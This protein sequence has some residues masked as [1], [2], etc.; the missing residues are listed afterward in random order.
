MKKILFVAN[1]TK[2]H[3]CK[4]HIPTIRVFKE[5][6]WTVDVAS[7]GDEEVPYCDHHFNMPWKRSPFTWKTI[8]GIF[9]LRK[10]IEDGKYDVVYC[11]TPVGGLVARLAARKARKYGTKVVY[12]AHGLHF[13]H[14]A[15]L[16][17][18]LLYYPVEKILSYFTDVLFVVNKD[19][20]QQA[21]K[22]L[23][24]NRKMQTQLVPGVGV[25]FE[26]L[27]LDNREEIRE[28]YR[29]TLGI[30][31][32]TTA[33]IYVAE[34]V[35]NKNQMMLVDVLK[36]LRE[37]GEDVVLLLPGPEHS[38]IIRS[39]VQKAGMQDYVYLLGWRNDIGALLCCADI[40]T[41]SSIREGFGINL[42]EALY[43]ELPIVATDNRGH[44]EIIRDGENGFLV[45]IN[46]V[47]AMSERVLQL[48][49][50]EELRK[51]LSHFDVSAYDCNL[52][53]EKLYHLIDNCVEQSAQ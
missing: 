24:G 36:K 12:C 22:L 30:H 3:I 33:L 4:F 29:N 11:H 23:N 14:G 10:V 49:H 7:A 5:N 48:I 13:Y 47:D 34:L 42:V 38:T 18:W 1:V 17:N 50:N 6:G 35:P 41:A 26:R 27:K 20:Y 40:C 53:A 16:I 19:D 31:Q 21:R 28:E 51:R 46:D 15:P 45:A 8:D 43:C 2:E 37:Q 9:A 25:N 39:Y 32:N 44:R 52:V